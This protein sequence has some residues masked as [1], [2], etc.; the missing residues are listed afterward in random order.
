MIAALLFT[1]C[2]KTDED[3]Q[4]ETKLQEQTFWGL[5]DDNV[6][7]DTYYPVYI[8]DEDNEGYT[9]IANSMDPMT[10]EVRNNELRIYYDNGDAPDY[11]QRIGYDKYYSRTVFRIN[12]FSDTQLEVTL[13][14][15][16]GY[17]SNLTMMP[18]D[19]A[20]IDWN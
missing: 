12:E 4:R 14:L 1:T 9:T 3:L 15:F 10:W 8:F 6:T 2:A 20:E 16:G 19:T 11:R 7:L 18:V 5:H 17:Q 13:Y